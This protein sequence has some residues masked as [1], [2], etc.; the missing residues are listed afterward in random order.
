M[1]ILRPGDS[2]T[3]GARP[4]TPGRDQEIKKSRL[5]ADHTRGTGGAREGKYFTTKYFAEGQNRTKI[6][7]MKMVTTGLV[8][9]NQKLLSYAFAAR[10]SADWVTQPRLIVRARTGFAAT[11][12]GNLDVNDPSTCPTS[13]DS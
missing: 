7:C 10:G 8:G 12:T 11:I 1:C 2:A 9:R 4:G 5:R 3:L 6:Y 13:L